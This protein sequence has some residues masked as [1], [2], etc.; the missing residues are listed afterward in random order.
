LSAIVALSTIASLSTSIATSAIAT[1]ATV[2]RLAVAALTLRGVFSQFGHLLT[3][4]DFKVDSSSLVLEVGEGV[5]KALSLVFWH[6]ED[7][8]LLV[9]EAA[10][11]SDVV[12]QLLGPELSQN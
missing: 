3:F 8:A 9:F 11:A 2:A 7:S 4:L 5:G 12:Q 6:V 10:H 1:L